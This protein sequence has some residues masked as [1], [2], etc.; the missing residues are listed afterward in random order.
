V[1]R[2]SETEFSSGRPA[3]TSLM[4]FLSAKICGFGADLCS[5]F[6]NNVKIVFLTSLEWF[7]TTSS[8][9]FVV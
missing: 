6:S 9:G 3:F 1:L 7:R 2:N 8:I 4:I 5:H